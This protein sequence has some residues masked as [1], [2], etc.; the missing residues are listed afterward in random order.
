MP[1]ETTVQS[2]IIK[3]LNSLPKGIAENISG[4]A[5]QSGRSDINACVCGRTFKIEV[6]TIDT[7]YGK[8]GATKKQLHYLEQWGNSGAFSCVVYSVEDV[9]KVLVLSG[10]IESLAFEKEIKPSGKGVW[11]DSQ[12]KRWFNI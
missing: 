1:T 11:Y 5:Q 2:S 8:K 6:K 9:K 4:Y 12:N 7:S 3:Y 10:V